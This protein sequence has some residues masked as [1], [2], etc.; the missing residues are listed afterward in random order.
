MVD[1]SCLA[2]ALAEIGDA[3][4]RIREVLPAH[5]A[6]FLGDRTVREVVVLNLFVALQECLSI[7]THWLADRGHDVP[8]GYREV[9]ELLCRHGVLEPELSSR[10]ATAMGLRSLIVHRYGV[11]DWKH[12][13]E[14]ASTRLA[15]LDSFCSV[16]V[17]RADEE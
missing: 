6:G 13:Y 8:A 15:D 10:L 9:F 12:V 4:R 14:I 3:V 7:S 17:L 16:L 2:K 5:I 1:E 11:L